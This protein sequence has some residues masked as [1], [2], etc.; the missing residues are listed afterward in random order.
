MGSRLRNFMSKKIAKKTGFTLIEVLIAIA[1]LS[2]MVVAMVI[3]TNQIMNSKEETEKLDDQSHSVFLALNRISSDLQMA[4]L[5]SGTDFL[6]TTGEMKIAFIG[7][8]DQMNFASFSL[9][10]YFKGEQEFD[11][12]EV[13]YSIAASKNES[14][15]KSLYRREQKGFDITP[16]EGGI[17]EPILENIRSIHFQYYDSQ[18]KEWLRGWDTTQ[19]DFSNRLPEMVKIEMEVEN[20]QEEGKPLSFSTIAGIKLVKGIS[21]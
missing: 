12:G 8:E 4:F 16:E 21:F 20:L 3:S 7:K 1:I 14:R 18:K 17:S 19:L 2:G 6:G 5:V 13:G 11:Y 15:E 10:R 9:A